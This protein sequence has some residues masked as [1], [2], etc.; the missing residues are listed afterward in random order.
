MENHNPCSAN[1]YKQKRRNGDITKSP[2][3]ILKILSRVTKHNKQAQELLSLSLSYVSSGGY[4][5]TEVQYMKER[6]TKVHEMLH[7]SFVCLSILLPC[8]LVVLI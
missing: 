3:N 4:A 5:E 2:K 8:T 6:G 7:L 1:P